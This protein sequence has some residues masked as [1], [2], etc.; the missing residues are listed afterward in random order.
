MS[1]QTWQETLVVAE[2]DGTALTNSTTPTSIIPAA[3]RYTLPANYLDV[4]RSLRVTLKGRVSNLVTTPGTLTLEVRLGSVIAFT[5][6]AIQLSATAHTNVSLHTDIVLTCR[7]IGGGTTANLMGTGELTTEGIG[8]TANQAP[9][10]LLPVSAPAVGTGFDSTAAQILD[11]FATFSIASASNSI[12]IHQYILE[13][14][15]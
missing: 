10:A 15:N 6:G 3:A 12:Q 8:T 2:V 14:M 7:A 5:S 13:S 4:G 9:T 1:R 11:V